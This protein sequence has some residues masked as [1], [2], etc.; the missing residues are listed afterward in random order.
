M[1]QK[2]NASTNMTNENW[3]GKFNLIDGN[4]IDPQIQAGLPSK[5]GND[6]K[7]Q[8]ILITLSVVLAHSAVSTKHPYNRF[9]SAFWNYADRMS[10]LSVEPLAPKRGTSD[11]VIRCLCNFH[12]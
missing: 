10:L 5:Y 3:R 1:I 2:V 12:T 7:F 6:A 4:P 8:G 9:F 11:F